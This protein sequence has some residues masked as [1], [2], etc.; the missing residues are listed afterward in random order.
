M[1]DFQSEIDKLTLELKTS[2]ESDNFT[3]ADLQRFRQA[4]LQG[5]Q[6]PANSLITGLE[7]ETLAGSATLQ[8]LQGIVGGI[9]SRAVSSGRRRGSNLSTQRTRRTS[10]A[11]LDQ[12]IFKAEDE[13]RRRE[14][15]SGELNTAQ[16]NANNE[17]VP[18]PT[19]PV[20]D[21]ETGI[22]FALSPAEVEQREADDIAFS[23]AKDE[24]RTLM[25]PQNKETPQ[26]M[27][28][29]LWIS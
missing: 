24:T 4:I 17:F 22:P 6:G 15:L 13:L 9:N 20:F 27:P 1:A 29:T 16:E 19:T 8:G 14:R 5:G 18:P 25:L 11:A 28:L 26:I 23:T 7:A 2:E 10:L 12:E 3:R 21:P